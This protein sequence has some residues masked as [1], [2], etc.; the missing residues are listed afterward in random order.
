[1]AFIVVGFDSMTLQKEQM[2]VGR[3]EN[4]CTLSTDIQVC[5][6]FNKPE[7]V[8]KITLVFKELAC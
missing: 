4:T 6:F 8:I 1:M 2:E 7:D 3:L 5:F